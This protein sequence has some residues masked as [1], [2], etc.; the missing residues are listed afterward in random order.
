MPN[1]AVRHALRRL[2]RDRSLTRR[3]ASPSWRSES[4]R[5]RR[6]SASSTPCCSKPLPYPAADRLVVLRIFDPEYQ[7]RYPSFPVNAA[8]LAAWREHCAILRGSR[9]DRLDDDDTD[10]RRA[11]PSSSTARPSTAA[12]SPSSASLPALGRGFLAGEDRPGSNGVADHRP[13]AVDRGGSAAI[14][15]SSGARSARRTAGQGRRRAAGARAA[16]RTAA[17]RR[18]G[19]AAALDR[20]LPAR[21]RCRR[22]R[23][24]RGRPRLRRRGARALRESA[25]TSSAR[26]ST[27]LEPAVSKQTATTSAS[28]C[29]CSRCRQIVVR[30]ARGPLPCCSRRPSRSC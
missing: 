29:W 20:R 12:S 24:D 8:H 15:G 16:A 2:W 18:S 26:S 9:R 3:R 5:T 6:S 23:C 4:A 17:A 25:P 11:R 22:T 7:D 13:R 27:A 1:L 28:G 14:P 30:H 21:W 19:P 10:R